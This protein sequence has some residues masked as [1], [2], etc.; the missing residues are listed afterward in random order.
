MNAIILAGGK[1]TR[2]SRM[3]QWVPKATV[4]V[5][6]KPL[7]KHTVEKLLLHGISDISVCTGYK[8]EIVQT[9]LSGFNIR[10]YN[11]PFF[12]ITNSIA[13][14]WFARESIID[15]CII[16]NGD[17][18][19]EEDLLSDFLN[20]VGDY[21]LCVDSSRIEEGDYFL[22]LKP[23]GCLM[24]YG[25]ELDVKKRSCEYVGMAIVRKTVAQSF[26]MLLEKLINSQQHKLWWENTLYTLSD[27]GEQILTN[28]VNGKF[29]AEVDYF[30]EYERILRFVG[31]E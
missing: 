10:F 27:M 11:N 3:I 16:M 9:A 25:K 2:I 24:N 4:L 30:K 18:Y 23:D 22:E 7:I 19:F 21:I 31:V 29:W 1:G 20:S 17:V 13:S 8:K 12:D 26:R 28:D 6:E 5:G 15:D 14:L